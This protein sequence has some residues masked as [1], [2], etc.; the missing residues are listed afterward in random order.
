MALVM[1]I[2]FAGCQI[3]TGPI[4]EEHDSTIDGQGTTFT[5]GFSATVK[6]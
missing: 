5:G 4:V 1:A 2:A 6:D 3:E